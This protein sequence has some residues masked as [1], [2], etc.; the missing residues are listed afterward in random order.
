MIL[1]PHEALYR[2]KPGSPSLVQVPGARFLAIDGTGS[3]DGEAFQA[4]VGA[5][6]AL[7]CS[8]KFALKKA[9]GVNVKV[10]PLED[11]FSADADAAD[12]DTA[13]RERLAWTLMLRLP[14]PQ[15]RPRGGQTQN[16]RETTNSVIGT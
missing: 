11:L 13:S 1:G 8:A 9:S 10:P 2:A 15:E 4:A 6:Y 12:F 3:P 7:A 14:E 16:G 5:L